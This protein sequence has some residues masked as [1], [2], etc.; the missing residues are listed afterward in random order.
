[1]ALKTRQLRAS[2][3]HVYRHI[4]FSY[5]CEKDVDECEQ[6]A[7]CHNGAVCENTYGSYVCHCE[8]GYTG[9]HCQEVPINHS[10]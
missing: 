10:E 8:Q 6:S 9:R 4:A 1:M 7:P 5:F 2:V 3:F